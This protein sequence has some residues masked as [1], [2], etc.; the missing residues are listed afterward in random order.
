LLIKLQQHTSWDDTEI[1]KIKL[2]NQHV[3]I[4]RFQ[5]SVSCHENGNVVSAYKNYFCYNRFNWTSRHKHRDAT[6]WQQS[7]TVNVTWPEWAAVAQCLTGSSMICPVMHPEHNVHMSV[8]SCVISESL[9]HKQ[10]SNNVV[11]I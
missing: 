5:R 8:N 9:V 2:I 6:R 7:T 11:E 3:L 1:G 4:A 10:T